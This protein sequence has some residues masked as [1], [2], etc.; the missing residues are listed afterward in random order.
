MTQ[1][2]SVG[3]YHTQQVSQTC[4]CSE[5]LHICPH[6]SQ[7]FCVKLDDAEFSELWGKTEHNST[8]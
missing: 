1:H 2:V 5:V 3:S 4:D 7:G 8:E 6:W